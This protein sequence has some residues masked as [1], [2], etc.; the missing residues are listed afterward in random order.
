MGFFL[1]EF[2]YFQW[3]RRYCVGEG[4]RHKIGAWFLPES[5]ESR[6]GIGDLL[7]ERIWAGHPEA[8]AFLW[9]RV[10]R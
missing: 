3:K 8:L 5:L 2:P 6:I 1:P 9:A 4:G 10:E 7:T